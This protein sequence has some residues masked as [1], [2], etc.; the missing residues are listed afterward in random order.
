MSKTAVLDPVIDEMSAF[1]SPNPAECERQDRH[2]DGQPG[3]QLDQAAAGHVR[4]SHQ[5]GQDQRDGQRDGGPH[6]RQG[7]T[8]PQCTD[9]RRIGHRGLP[10]REA[11]TCWL[12][13]GRH[14]EAVGEE[15]RQR[16]RQDNANQEWQ[17]RRKEP[18]AQ[19]GDIA[20]ISAARGQDTVE[21][22]CHATRADAK[23]SLSQEHQ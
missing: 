19:R 12:S 11:E 23:C 18:H 4:A 17:A 13:S 2:E 8:V 9:G 15:H 10:V 5:P 3:E 20:A 1:S 21:C 7:E 14:V 22:A 16:Q 6:D